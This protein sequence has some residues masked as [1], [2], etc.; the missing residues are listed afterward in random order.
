MA[1]SDFF[2]PARQAFSFFKTNKVMSFSSVGILAACLLLIIS[3]VL[4]LFN[5]NENISDIK[6]QNEVVVFIEDGTTEEQITAMYDRIM[7]IEGVDGAV[8]VSKDVAMEDY[9]SEFSEP[10][11][12]NGL[13]GDENPLSDSY[14]IHLSDIE[15]I[16]SVLIELEKIPEIRKIRSGKDLLDAITSFSN[17]L[18]FIIFWIVVI[19]TAASLFIIVNTIKL[20]RHSYRRHINIMRYVGATKWFIRWPFIIEGAII[21]VL[22]GIVSFVIIAVLY[23]LLEQKIG[24]NLFIQIIEFKRLY[25]LCAVITVSLGALLGLFGSAISIRKYLEA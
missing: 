13:V 12:L 22:A 19:M 11:L 21:G 25:G 2:Y 6:N 10:E 17:I 9:K 18:S 23:L 1:A 5:V 16:D 4:M 24:G 14:K 20:A 7:D 3:F 8:F 15:K